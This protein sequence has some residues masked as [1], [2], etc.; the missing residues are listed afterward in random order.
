MKIAVSTAVLASLVAPAVSFS[1]LEG[2]GGGV[3]SIAAPSGATA[4]AGYLDALTS[5]VSTAPTGGGVVGYLDALPANGAAPVT[6]AGINSFANSMS[7]PAP[8]APVAAAPVPQAAAVPAAVAE[9]S[10]P[11]T[12][13]S[14]Y[15]DSVASVSSAGSPTG[16][17][18][19]GY[20]D[21]LPR[22]VAEV[23]GAGIQTF[24]DAI[25]PTSMVQG[26]SG[27][28]TYLSVLSP[29]T[30][31]SKSFSPFGAKPQAP[32]FVGS[33][34]GSE[35]GFTLET[36]DLASLLDQLRG[37]GGSIRLT[38]SIDSVSFV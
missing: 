13:G 12:A 16:G 38:G 35:I 17:G 4:G 37:S 18:V 26:G 6:G 15:L 29:D 31:S 33:V 8:V 24:K 36:G 5:P 23:G 30:G 25:Q 7:A 28:A 19:Q 27:M 20:L 11:V 21:V 9:S 3:A 2:L 22:N 14:S 34:S 1:Y 32:S 10:G